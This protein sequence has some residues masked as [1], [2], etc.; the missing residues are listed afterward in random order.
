MPIDPYTALLAAMLCTAILCATL[1]CTVALLRANRSDVVAVVR[2]LPELA[3]T[4]IR[5]RRRPR[6]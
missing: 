3:A 1:V 4:L 6:R 5:Y 2:A